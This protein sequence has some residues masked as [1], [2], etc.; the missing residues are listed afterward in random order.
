MLMT[1]LFDEEPALS[2]EEQ[3][4]GVKTPFERYHQSFW[5]LG[6][7]FLLSRSVIRLKSLKT[8]MEKKNNAEIEIYN[9]TSF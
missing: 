4:P 7:S 9:V 5:H 3:Q 1:L 6:R 2:P 8:K